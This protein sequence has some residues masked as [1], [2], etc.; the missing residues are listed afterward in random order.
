MT[1]QEKAAIIHARMNGRYVVRQ[2]GSHPTLIQIHSTAWD[3]VEDY[4]KFQMSP[5][6]RTVALFVVQAVGDRW[7]ELESNLMGRQSLKALANSRLATYEDYLKDVPKIRMDDT[8]P[9][10][11]SFDVKAAYGESLN[12]ELQCQHSEDKLESLGPS[13][14]NG[15][16]L[17]KCLSCGDQMYGYLAREP[18]TKIFRRV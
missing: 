15:L 3:S 5:N 7:T 10:Y 2:V 6:E 1:L 11:S 14:K 17:L 8:L 18:A 12:N 16:P 13:N 9:P 4:F